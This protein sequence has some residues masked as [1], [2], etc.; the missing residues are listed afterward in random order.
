MIIRDSKYSWTL[1]KPHGFE[2]E[3]P[4]KHGW[5]SKVNT[6]LLHDSQLVE[7]QVQ[8]LG[9]GGIAYKENQV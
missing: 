2:C 3:G 5:F 6:A 8:N 7:L 9:Y 4:F 1:N